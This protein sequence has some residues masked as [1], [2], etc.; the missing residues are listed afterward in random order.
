M[1]S[2]HL[3]SLI[4]QFA[5]CLGLQVA[6]PV[7]YVPWMALLVACLGWL[8]SVAAQVQEP[9]QV[10]VPSASVPSASVPSASVP[11]ANVPSANVP[12]AN[13][14]SANVPSANVPSA[15]VP[16]LEMPE[17]ASGE[18]VEV[19]GIGFD[20]REV[21]PSRSMPN[22]PTATMGGTQFWTDHRWWYGWRLQRNL[23]TGHWRLIDMHDVRRAWGSRE[24]CLAELEKRQRLV[25][26]PEIQPDMVVLVHGLMRSTDSMDPVAEAVSKRSGKL[27]AAFGYAST[28]A[29]IDEHASALREWVENLPGQPRIS[30]VAHSLGNIVVRRAIAMWQQDGDPR[31]VLPRLHRM[32]MLGPPNQ[33][34]TIARRLA[35]LRLFE[36]VTGEAGQE[37]GVAW[38]RMQMRLATPPF[39]FCIVAGDVSS[40]P[41]RNPLVAGESDFV[42]SVE[43]TRLEGAAEHVTVPALHSFLMSD[44]KVLEITLQ[45]LYQ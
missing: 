8:G 9:T 13:V 21:A 15:N 37:L 6:R 45:F 23:L 18:L 29:A 31:L 5:N 40:Q 3:L 11:S 4:I 10:V 25:A 39:P 43:E 35:M 1:Q 26:P 17:A 7:P 33:G 24:A 14:P 34:A 12:S 2:H 44:E 19:H 32:V 36:T 28:R 22:L 30:F 16:V 20:A 42:V 27:P 38:E 41:V